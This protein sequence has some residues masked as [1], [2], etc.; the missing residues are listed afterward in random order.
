VGEPSVTTGIEAPPETVAGK[1]PPTL[2]PHFFDVN[3]FVAEAC[4]VLSDPVI[5]IVLPVDGT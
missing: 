1:P 4:Q 3:E 2:T 5:W